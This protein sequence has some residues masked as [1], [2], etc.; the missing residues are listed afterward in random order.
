MVYH[1]VN[2][3]GDILRT[4]STE[5]DAVIGVFALLIDT[6]SNEEFDEL[7]RKLYNYNKSAAALLSY[8]EYHSKNDK[9]DS[10][11]ERVEILDLF[12]Y[13]ELLTVFTETGN[14][15]ATRGFYIERE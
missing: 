11:R 2:D 8:Y 10:L 14:Y 5:E 12:E 7:V 9:T 6:L 13:D 4:Y 1:V 3:N 15:P